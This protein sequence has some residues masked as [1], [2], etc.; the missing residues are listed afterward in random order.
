MKKIDNILVTGS[1][2]VTG[3][4]VKRIS[5]KYKDKHFI[6]VDSSDLDLR[7]FKNT[8]SFLRNNKIDKVINLAAVSGGI[9]ISLKHPASM[10]RDNVLINLS[11]VEACVSCNIKKLLLTLT[12]GMYPENSK[13]P[14]IED[15]IHDGEP[16]KTNYGS[17]F[18]KRLIEPIIRSYREE[19]NLN[20]VGLIPSG[21][22][23]PEDNFH[24]EHAPMMP[25]IINRA[26]D[27]KKN[28]TNL[29]VWGTGKPLREYTFSEDIAEI[30]IWALDNFD[31][32]KPINIG[33]PEE[34]SIK[35]I[36]HLV[37]KKIG[38]DKKKIIFNKDKPDGIFK[39]TSS[40][41]KFQS[42]NNFKY[43]PMEEGINR[44]I[45]WFLKIKEKNEN[46][47]KESKIKKF[48]I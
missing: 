34:L 15:Y 13:L 47:L 25:A 48:N 23:G 38:L 41:K 33:S 2:G 16:S 20:V 27:A 43:M 28:N 45:D 6:F 8:Q 24:P 31:S 39:K 35:E 18:A 37:C 7:N 22:F 11:I 32:E 10:L 42:L 21:I 5:K 40:N 4:A 14:L 36:I 30:F 3:K 12:T 17:S 1:G 26:Y 46:Y 29:E 9:G 19:Y 44:T